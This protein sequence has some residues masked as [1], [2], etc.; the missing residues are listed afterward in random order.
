[1]QKTKYTVVDGKLEPFFETG[2][3]GIH[4]S[5]YDEKTPGYAGLYPLQ[6]GDYLTVFGPDGEIVWLGEVRLEFERNYRSYP[7]NP[8]Y[9]QQC[10]FPYGP[11]GPGLWVHGFQE[12]LDPEAWSRMFQQCLRAKLVRKQQDETGPPDEFQRWFRDSDDSLP[13]DYESP[14]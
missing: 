1:M 3:E 8:Q 4:W 9:G 11:D 14:V 12:T 6:N 13:S 2:S 10:S 5:L 7:A